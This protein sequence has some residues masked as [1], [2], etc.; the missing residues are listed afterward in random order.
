[1]VLSSIE[2]ELRH[3]QARRRGA[4]DSLRTLQNRIA[5]LREEAKVTT[6]GL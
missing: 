5:A 4:G 3:S 6:P 1:M 2:P